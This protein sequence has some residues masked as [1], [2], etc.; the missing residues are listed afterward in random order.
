[1]ATRFPRALTKKRNA[2]AYELNQLEARTVQVRQELAALDYTMRLLDPAWKAP[3]KAHRPMISRGLRHGDI[4]RTCLSILRDMPGLATPVLADYVAEERGV[5][6]TTQTERENFASSVAMALRRY[7][8]KG[9]LEIAGKH[10]STG[11]LNWRLC[12]QDTG[13]SNVLRHPRRL[14]S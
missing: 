13:G 2:L 12:D 7:E 1:M 3:R 10:P 4:A 11:A 14:A 8:R 9:L 5:R 6:L